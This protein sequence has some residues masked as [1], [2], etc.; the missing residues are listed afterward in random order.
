M[1][2]KISFKLLAVHQHELWS[3]ATNDNQTRNQ[4]YHACSDPLECIKVAVDTSFGAG[5]GA[6]IQPMPS[7]GVSSS[8]SSTLF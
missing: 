1:V 8:S 4:S 3:L 2:W 7:A 6:G 5:F